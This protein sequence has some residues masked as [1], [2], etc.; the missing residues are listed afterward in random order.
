MNHLDSHSLQVLG[1]ASLAFTTP[2]LLSQLFDYI[3][4]WKS[5]TI[6]PFSLF[7]SRKVSS[8]RSFQT[9]YS[10]VDEDHHA[11]V[12]L[13]ESATIGTFNSIG[14]QRPM[15]IAMVRLIIS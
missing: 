3:L 8:R 9:K 6:F 4:Q 11:K 15:V 5:F 14:L 12:D 13:P 2:I 1:L 7:P 10:I